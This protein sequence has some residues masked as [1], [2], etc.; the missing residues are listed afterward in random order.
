MLNITRQVIRGC[1]GGG[2]G[3]DDKEE[4][5]EEGD[6][7]EERRVELGGELEKGEEEQEQ[8][9][10]SFRLSGVSDFNSA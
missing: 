3:G 6:E 5:E 10:F 2:R 4:E 8:W 1:F 9:Y 7:A